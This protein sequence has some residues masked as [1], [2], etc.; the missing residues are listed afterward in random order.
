M[1]FYHSYSFFYAINCFSFCLV[2]FPFIV[3]F[4]VCHRQVLTSCNFNFSIILVYFDLN[5]ARSCLLSLLWG[6]FSFSSLWKFIYIY[7]YIR[8]YIPLVER[9]LSTYWSEFV[10][11]ETGQSKIS[12]NM[13]HKGV[14]RQFLMR[15]QLY[16]SYHLFI[17]QI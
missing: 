12:L 8:I 15:I 3:D 11:L 13:F 10:P 4:R 16:I 9:I 6:Y 2:R 7:I 1:N 14:L 17:F 5:F